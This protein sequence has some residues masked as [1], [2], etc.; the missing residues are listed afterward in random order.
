MAVTSHEQ[1]LMHPQR[2]EKFLLISNTLFPCIKGT[3]STFLSGE[4]CTE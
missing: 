3:L 4:L 1:R 2:K